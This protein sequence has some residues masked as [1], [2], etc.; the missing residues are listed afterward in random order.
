M[1]GDSIPE[2][3]ETFFLNVSGA[4]GATIVDGQGQATILND[5]P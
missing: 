3:D 1:I 5:D 2:P 4:M